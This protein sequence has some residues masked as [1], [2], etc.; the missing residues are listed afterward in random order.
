MTAPDLMTHPT[1]ETLAAFVDDTLH[2]NERRTVMQHLAACGECRT[3]V[4]DV[5]DVQAMDEEAGNVVAFRRQGGWRVAAASIAVAAGLVVVFSGPIREWAFGAS[6][7]DL[8]AASEALATR[9]TQGRLAGDFPH[10]DA[11]PVY[12]GPAAEEGD[13][14]PQLYKVERE[15]ARL[16]SAIWRDPHKLGVAYLLAGDRDRAIESLRAAAQTNPAVNVDLAAALLARA[17]PADLAEALAL[18]RRSDAPEALWNRAVALAK[19][20]RDDEAIA[21]WTA[22]LNVDSSSKWAEEARREIARLEQLKALR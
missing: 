11:E 4:L 13:Y 16:E 7:D 3:L 2:R 12:R 9:P 18:S 8:V 22:Y 17:R 21:A 19:L 20:N 10:R 1:D 6:M 15:V 14:D 5:H